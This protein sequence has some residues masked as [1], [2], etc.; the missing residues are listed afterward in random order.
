VISLFNIAISI[1]SSK[2][3]GAIGA[4]TIAISNIT[5]ITAIKVRILR[6]YSLSIKQFYIRFKNKINYINFLLNISNIVLKAI[7][8]FIS[9]EI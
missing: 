1:A 5:N 4:I 7:T 2:V 3:K 9:N 6:N 8:K